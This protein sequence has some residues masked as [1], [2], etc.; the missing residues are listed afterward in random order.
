MTAQ[1]HLKQLIRTRMQ[2]TG[3][4]YAT[5]RRQLIGKIQPENTDPLTRW[6]FPGNVPATTAL[7]ILLTH[8][9]L[10]APHT[11]EP[12]SEAMLFGIAGGIGIGVFSFFYEREDFASFFVAGRHQW[13][14]DEGY[15][16]NALIRFGLK[17]VVQESGGATTAAQQL[18]AMLEQNGPSIAWVDMAGLPHRALPK[19]YSGGG[20]HVIIVYRVDEAGGTALIGDSTDE[21]ISIPLTD[22]GQARARIKK[23]KNRLLSLASIPKN[24]KQ[25]EHAALVQAGLK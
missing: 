15:L 13:H 16:K 17:P 4:R 9:G 3:E 18:R 5:A 1:K 8:H 6:H 20:Y 24:Y 23:Q 7:R 14:D 25:P 21:P 19:Q 11:G 2:K 12:F 10:R 22:L